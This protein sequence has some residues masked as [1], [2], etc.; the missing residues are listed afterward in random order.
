M[1]VLGWILQKIVLIWSIMHFVNQGTNEAFNYVKN[2]LVILLHP[3]LTLVQISIMMVVQE[4]GYKIFLTICAI[5][6]DKWFCTLPTSVFSYHQLVTIK[7]FFVMPNL[8][9]ENGWKNVILGATSFLEHVL[10]YPMAVV[11]HRLLLPPGKFLDDV[12]VSYLIYSLLL[13]PAT[14]R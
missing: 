11:E 3:N 2:R 4:L 8:S 1:S 12:G 14:F 6:S 10:S 9:R 7:C 13:T 5:Q